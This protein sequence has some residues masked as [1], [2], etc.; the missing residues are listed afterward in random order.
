[1][2]RLV[3]VGLGFEQMAEELDISARHARRLD[4]R[5]LR[6]ALGRARMREEARNQRVANGREVVA[7][8]RAELEA[9]GFQRHTIVRPRPSRT[10]EPTTAF[11]IKKLTADDIQGLQ[12]AG[13]T[14]EQIQAVRQVGSE[15]T[16]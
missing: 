3:A 12:A 6:R 7:A 15:P 4:T 2:H 5:R 9:T 8:L 10:L 11:T 14:R 13:L 1:V 16:S